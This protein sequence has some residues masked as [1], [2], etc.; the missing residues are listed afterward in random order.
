MKVRKLKD[1]LILPSKRIAYALKKRADF[2]WSKGVVIT[3]EPGET[4][5]EFRVRLRK[6]FNL[7][8][9]G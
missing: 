3:A 8:T 6:F 1:K 2:D 5:E 4:F 7:E 9:G